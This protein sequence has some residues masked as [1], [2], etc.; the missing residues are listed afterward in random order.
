MHA[1]YIRHLTL[2]ATSGDWPQVQA[3]WDVFV[4]ATDLIAAVHAV[5]VAL[6]WYVP[7]AV[8]AAADG[9]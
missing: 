1:N 4:P 7:A 3:L 6:L 9:V 5:G 2:H 8:C